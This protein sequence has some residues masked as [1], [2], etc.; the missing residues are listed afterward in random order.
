VAARFKVA[1]GGAISDSTT[2]E[3]AEFDLGD[4]RKIE[5]GK[6]LHPIFLPEHLSFEEFD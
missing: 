3:Q 6:P 4:I 5:A 1:T 2:T